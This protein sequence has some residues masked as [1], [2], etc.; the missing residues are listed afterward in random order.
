M[1]SFSKF[2]DEF[3]TGIVSNLAF[4]IQFCAGGCTGPT[5]KDCLACKNFYDDGELDKS[6]NFSSF[7]F[8]TNFLLPPLKVNANKNAQQC[9][10][11]TQQT[12]CGSQTPTESSLTV[13]LVSSTAL[14]ICLK[15]TERVSARVHR[16]KWPRMVNACNAMDLARRLVRAKESCILA[17]L[18]TIAAAQSSKDLWRFLIKPSAATN[19]STRTSR[20]ARDS[21]ESIPIAW[22]CFRH[23]KKSPVIST[24]KGTK[25]N[26]RI[27]RT[28]ETWKSSAVVSSKR[29]CSRH[30]SL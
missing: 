22:K 14:N 20:S 5:Q 13:Q 23:S 26:S 18:T 6:K 3:L 15:I 28:S 9:K 12:T 17:T 27:C 25:I 8:K 7:I 30:S 2:F 11:T 16:T 19:K 29:T 24:S 10:S 1:L 4:I 21:S